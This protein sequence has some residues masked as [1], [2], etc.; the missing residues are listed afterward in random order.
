MLFQIPNIKLH[1]QAN[2]LDACPYTVFLL[3]S[4]VQQNNRIANLP[5]PIFNSDDLCWEFFK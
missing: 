5:N 1:R 3:F 4:Y 2:W